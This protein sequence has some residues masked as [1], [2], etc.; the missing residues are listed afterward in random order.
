MIRKASSSNRYEN[1]IK[2]IIN[3]SKSRDTLF[4]ENALDAGDRCDGTGPLSV[5]AGDANGKVTCSLQANQMSILGIP[6][7]INTVKRERKSS[8]QDEV[9]GWFGVLSRSTCV[10]V[11]ARQ[12]KTD[13][14]ALLIRVTQLLKAVADCVPHT[15]TTEEPVV[16]VPAAVVDRPAVAT[17]VIAV[18][19]SRGGGTLGGFRLGRAGRRGVWRHLDGTG[20]PVALVEV[21]VVGCAPGDVSRLRGARRLAVARFG[22][23]DGHGRSGPV[24][25]ERRGQ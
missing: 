16:R 14:S 4:C 20:G 12:T 19:A 10:V 6:D 13:H 15:E 1:M 3:A 22:D 25:E 21:G 7:S 23:L 17:V 2:R 5:L 8:S 18:L 11:K 9:A 24:P